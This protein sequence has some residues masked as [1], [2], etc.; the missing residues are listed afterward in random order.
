M[1]HLYPNIAEL[2]AFASSAKHLNFSY[3]A[4]ELGLTPSAVSRQI[5]NLETLFGVKLFVREGRNLS[6]TRAGQVY[7][8]RVTGPL[9]E[10]G[11]ASLELLSVRE[12]S[13]L[14]TI[15]SVPTFTTK[16]LVPRLPSFLAAAPNVTLSFRR[17]LAHGDPFPFGL[18]AAIRYGDGRW[19][20]VRCDYLAGRTFVPVCSPEFAAKHALRTPAD[21]AAAPRLVHEQAESVW[22][23]WAERHRVTSMNAFSGPRFEQYA[24]LIQAAQAG[25]GLALVPAFL[26]G[27]PLEA[28]SLVQPVAAPIEV[29]NQGHYLCYTAERFETSA[30]LRRLREWMLGEFAAQ[31]AASARAA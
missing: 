28:G 9:R 6:L 29:D 8:A 14:L 22:F 24:V 27:A 10:I 12:D 4:R 2:H 25:L 16:W 7:H 5:A 21:L 11:N 20:G 15:A 13:D 23:E 3:A 26:I 30:A 17:H 31:A 19:E 1:K 18:D